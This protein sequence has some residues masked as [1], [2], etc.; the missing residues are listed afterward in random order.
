MS[1]GTSPEA[2]IWPVFPSTFKEGSNSGGPPN[3]SSDRI[4]TRP[5]RKSSKR[6]F[7]SRRQ[8]AKANEELAGLGARVS[9][10]H[11]RCER[12]TDEVARSAKRGVN[13]TDDQV[14][15]IV[16]HLCEQLHVAIRLKGAQSEVFPPNVKDLSF[17][18]ASVRTVLLIGLQVA[19][20]MIHH[21]APETSD[22]PPWS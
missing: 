13:M 2:L 6:R 15:R 5:K 19:G 1:R 7:S 4:R 10:L 22:E 14:N 12:E 18:P 11:Q 9:S 8:P 16:E 3:S 20:V 17:D 21:A